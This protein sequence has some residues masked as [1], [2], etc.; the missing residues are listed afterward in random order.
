MAI[1][2]AGDFDPDMIIQ[3]VDK[4]FG[5][6][7]TKEM[8]PYI[9]TIE[10]D[11]KAPISIEVFGPD[12][13]QV[14]FGFRFPGINSKEA[15]LLTITDMILNNGKAGLI[16]I[17]LT[18]AQKLLQA[19]CYADI[20]TDYSIH[21][22]NGKPKQGQSLEEVKNLLLAQIELI[23]KGDFPDWI[24]S[25]IINEMKLNQIKTLES[26]WGR[27][28]EFVSSFINDI[29]WSVAL[30]RID[31]L[32]KITKQDVIEFAKKHYNANYVVAYKK[33][34]VDPIVDKIKKPHIT[35]IVINRESKSDLFLKIENQKPLAIEPVF[36]DFTKVISKLNTKNN[37]EII[38][39]KNEENNLFSLN[40]L[41]D[42][43]RNNSK[44]LEIAVNY[45]KY[46][47]TSKYSSVQIKQEFYKIGCD[48]G[49]YSSSDRV[50]VYLSGLSENM[51]KG[52]E[53][54]EHLLSEVKPDQTALA[55]LKNDIIK[56]RV[57]AKLNK[58]NISERM[59]D[60]AKY[61]NL[62]PSTN[63]LSE[64]ELK[65][66]KA[67]ELV[68][69]IKNL[70]NYKHNAFY[71]GP[72][73]QQEVLTV[74]EKY[75][76]TPQVLK[77]LP[78]ETKFTEKE[79]LKNQVYVVDYDM[80]Q[81]ELN[82][83]SKSVLFDKALLPEVSIFNEYFGNNMGSVVFQEL[84]E[85]KGL[86]YTAWAGYIQPNRK[87]KAFYIYSFIGTQNDKLSEAMK[88]MSDLLTNMPESNTSF[89]NSKTAIINQIRSE[90]VTKTD[91]LFRYYYYQKLGINY[92][93]RKD[94][95]N[96]VPKMNF[97]DLKNFQEK[98]IK[99]KN[100]ITLVLG[101]KKKLDVKTLQKYG[102]VKFLTLKEIFGY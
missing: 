47:G 75:H 71:Y 1:T 52:F 25:A 43:G 62:S 82:M 34:G 66:L 102:E 49:V 86:A 64:I 74:I 9:P 91:I 73:N 20:R 45:F 61:G 100:Y 11:I 83:V 19:Y 69:I 79:T 97:A 31:E 26:N 68:S 6:F 15:G 5:S 90:R 2:M 88:G 98:Y 94:I 56:E 95:F 41:F 38:Y 29:P 89:E 93:V 46:L 92:D 59:I 23:K 8:N 99:R 33:T 76:Q 39:T 77:E 22:F 16:D 30:R 10:D 4:Y 7:K 57:N 53:L 40:Y 28:F 84:R 81:V 36:L 17:N 67:E 32:S 54:F 3:L 101:K 13:E 58:Y 80:K 50:E 21:L 55:N 48:Y 65:A 42:M 44:K 24:I 14:L 12:E 35:P 78:I 87:D 85:A 96:K 70:K 51:E 18:Q 63:L 27:S 60:Y 72:M 37:F